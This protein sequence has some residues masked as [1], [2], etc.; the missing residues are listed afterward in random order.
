MRKAIYSLVVG[1]YFLLS[2]GVVV[3]LHYCMDR[4]AEVGLFADEHRGDCADC[5][6][7]MD[8][9]ND[10]C[11]DRTEVIKLVQDQSFSQSLTLV[12]K[13][14]A[15][16]TPQ[17]PVFTDAEETFE[18]SRIGVRFTHSENEWGRYRYRRLSV[19]KI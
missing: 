19:F 11:Q 1:V 7:A 17:L 13:F 10:C 15:G 16:Q 4:L 3:Q 18:F 14:D 2:C 8:A 12:G 9:A 6:M 5:G